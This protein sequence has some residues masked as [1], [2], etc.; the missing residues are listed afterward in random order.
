MLDDHLGS[1]ERSES[2][3]ATREEQEEIITNLYLAE[4]MSSDSGEC[5]VM[6]SNLRIY[7]KSRPPMYG[8]VVVETVRR[9]SP[10]S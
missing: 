9:G 4:A 5:V 3:M 10:W 8:R 1:C 7:R 6:Y 2:W